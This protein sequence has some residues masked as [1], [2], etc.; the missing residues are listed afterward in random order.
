MDLFLTRPPRRAKSARREFYVSCRGA[1][2]PPARVADGEYLHGLTF[3]P[4]KDAVNAVTPAVKKVAHPLLAK[5]RLGYKGTAVGKLG[6]AP[7]G[8]A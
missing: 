5:A 6:K 8:V 7:D 1:E 3:D 2:E 4:V